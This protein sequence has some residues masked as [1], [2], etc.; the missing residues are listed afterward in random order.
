M[1]KSHSYLLIALVVAGVFAVGI[2]RFVNEP[3]NDFGNSQTEITLSF[4]EMMQKVSNDTA[5]LNMLKDK[6]VG[7]TGQVK[8]IT[9]ADSTY[10][11]EL[12]DENSMSSIICQIDA[13]HA[14]DF[15]QVKPGDSLGIKGKMIGYTID[16]ELGFGNTVEMNYCSRIKK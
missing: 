6:L 10:T 2:F 3:V 9:R 16:T 15:D 14:Q 7:I 4:A 1:K 5:S 8:K 11:L 13:R 12:G